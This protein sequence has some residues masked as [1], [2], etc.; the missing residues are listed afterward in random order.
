MI[1][2]KIRRDHVQNKQVK[3]HSKQFTIIVNVTP[4]VNLYPVLLLLVVKF[5]FELYSSLYRTEQI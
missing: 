3:K 4:N 5:S 2:Y 1:F